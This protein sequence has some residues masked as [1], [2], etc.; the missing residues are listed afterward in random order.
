VRP[1]ALLASLLACAALAGSATAASSEQELAEKYVP[2]VLLKENPDPPCSRDGEQFR[3][4]TVDVILGNPEVNLVR[5]ASRASQKD[6]VVKTAPTAQDIGGLGP[7]YYLDLEGDPESP[8]CR[9]AE[10][11]ARIGAGKPAVTYAHVARE[12]GIPRLVVQYWLYWYFNQFNDQH[13]SDW[14]MIQLAFDTPSVVEA[15]AKGPY[16]VAYAQHGGGEKHGW[17]DP[18][19]QKESTH[20]V[21]WVASGSHASQFESVL[22]L[23]TGENGSGL[24]CDDTR[25]PSERVALTPILVPTSP[26]TGQNT[27]WATYEGLWGQTARGFNNGITGPN[28]KPQWREPF[29]WMARLRKST[30]TVPGTATIGPSVTSFFCGAV[31]SVSGFL[32]T[33]SRTPLIAL[34]IVLAVVF[35]ITIPATR[36]R[37]DSPSPF[38]LRRRRAGGQIFRSAARLYRLHAR[39]LVPVALVAV[40]LGAMG[41]GFQTALF[42]LTGFGDWL[43]S[44]APAWIGYLASVVTGGF[45]RGIAY[46]LVAAAV[47]VAIERADRDQPLG[48]RRT[49]RETRGHFWALVGSWV[50]GLTVVLLLALT[51]VGIPLAIWVAVN[52]SLVQQEIVFNDMSIRGAFR[53]SRRLVKGHWLRTAIIAA[54]ISLIGFGSGPVLGVLLVFLSDV[55]LTFVNAFGSLVFALLIP[56]MAIARTML[57]CDL[58]AERDGLP[59]APAADLDGAARVAGAISPL[60]PPELATAGGIVYRR[61]WLQWLLTVATAGLWAVV[62]TYRAN[63]ELRDYSRSV[64]RPVDTGAGL[65]ALLAAAHPLGVV[66]GVIPAALTSMNIRTVQ[67][68]LPSR[69]REVSPWL[70]A[71][72]ALIFFLHVLYLQSALNEVERAGSEPADPPA[73]VL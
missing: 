64:G 43:D 23:S 72:A 24:G 22:Y 14:E 25:G 48:F 71:A 54:F 31:A 40:P 12:P 29:R 37:W 60:A 45:A 47:V 42:D 35:A 62:W 5:E 18:T 39:T 6:T 52:W 30:P 15:I 70:A 19:V 8:G 38:P 63:L 56:Y 50:G 3:P 34:A 2:V 55:S 53:E 66:F 58:E 33:A 11:F 32:T 10:D 73:P 27:A 9:Y 59:L 26:T 69:S 49:W 20:P 57:F 44:G 16:V 21:V 17:G 7:D 28:T 67:R 46:A 13:E 68:W 4:T 61:A 36:T 1:G 65:L 51:V 41:T